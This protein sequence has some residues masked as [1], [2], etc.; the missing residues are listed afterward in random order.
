MVMLIIMSPGFDP[1][2]GEENLMEQFERFR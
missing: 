2:G 1:Q